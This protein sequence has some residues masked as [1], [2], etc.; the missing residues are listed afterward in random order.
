MTDY[1]KS[2][3]FLLFT[4]LK[5][6]NNFTILY[7]TALA[8]CIS[9]DYSKPTSDQNMSF[10]FRWKSFP[11]AFWVLILSTLL[12]FLITICVIF[13]EHSD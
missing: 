5:F 10:F 4:V 11:K 9:D 8:Y 7:F 3:A 2:K 13:E 12:F 6:C 1:H